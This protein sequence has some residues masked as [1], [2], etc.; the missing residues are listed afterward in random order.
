MNWTWNIRSRDGGMNGLEFSRSTTAGG[1]SRVLVHAAPALMSV[2]ITDDDGHIIARADL[3]RGGDY[4]PMTLLEVEGGS[5]RRT[6][7]WPS[8]EL[9]GVPVILAGGEAGV[10]LRWR[11][12]DDR[13]WWRWSLELANHEGRPADWGPSDEEATTSEVEVLEAGA[14]VART[15]SWQFLGADHGDAG[16]SFFIVD[17]APG[18]G[19]ELHVH[20]YAEVFVIHEGEAAFVVGEKNMVAVAGQVVVAP[21][22]QPHMF[23]NTGSGRLRMT[24]IHDNRRMVTEFVSG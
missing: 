7:V 17:L 15:G 22:A 8:D 16:V 6:E 11:H 19:P 3:D 4:S 9:E 1:C 20:P 21:A 5:M 12:S 2:E 18:H 14:D 24:N 13:S 10:L 23:K